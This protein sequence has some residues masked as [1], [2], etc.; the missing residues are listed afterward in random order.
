MSSFPEPSSDRPAQAAQQSAA[1]SSQD[2]MIDTPVDVRKWPFLRTV[3]GDCRDSLVA[4]YTH[5][6][7][8]AIYAQ[9]IHRY[10]VIAAALLATAA[11]GLAVFQLVLRQHKP[12]AASRLVIPELLAV[13]GALGAFHF[14]E[15]WRERWLINRNKAERCR[16]LKFSSLIDPALWSIESSSAAECRPG[17]AAATDALQTISYEDVKRWSDDDTFS[18]PPGRITPRDT[19]ELA[20]LRGYYRE[21]RLQRQIRYFEEQYQRKLRRDRFWRRAPVKLFTYSV[22]LV[23]VHAVLEEFLKGRAPEQLLEWLV[24]FAVLLPAVGAGIRTWRSAHENTRN[25]TRFRAKHLALSNILHRMEADPLESDAHA[26]ALLRDLWCAEQI[27]ESE[28]REWLRL[29][30]DAEWLG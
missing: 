8:Q 12:E 11:V 7:E 26:E 1:W 24:G 3:L 30:L 29:M 4:I 6:D 13:I 16:L 19:I 2:D 27:M 22:A 15:R 21:K 28:H 17:L 18:L 5:A 10:W 9:R 14:G 23:A 25:T 20:E